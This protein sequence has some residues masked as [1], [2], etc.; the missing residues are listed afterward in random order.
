[1]T[2]K[3]IESSAKILPSE[4]HKKREFQTQVAMAKGIVAKA[5]GLGKEVYNI[6]GDL[7]RQGL[8][9]EQIDKAF[10]DKAKATEVI[11][12]KG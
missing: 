9:P 7:I 11:K 3:I 1:M 6:E 10:I 12:G 8:D 4:D 5:T 2:D